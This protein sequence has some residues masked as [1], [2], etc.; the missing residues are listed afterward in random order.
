MSNLRV[1]HL[2]TPDVHVVHPDDPIARVRELMS[3]QH[4]RHVTEV[5]DDGGVV[6][7]VSER[8]LLRRAAGVDSEVPLSVSDDV[9]AAVR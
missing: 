2:M 5:E 3:E 7:L 1:R 6:G 4:I 8:D 9:S